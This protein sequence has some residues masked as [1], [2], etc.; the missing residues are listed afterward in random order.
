VQDQSAPSA[1]VPSLRE[2]LT[3]VRVP[4][5]EDDEDIREPVARLLTALG[6]KTQVVVTYAQ[7]EAALAGKFDVLVADLQLGSERTGRD[8]AQRSPPPSAARSQKG[9]GPRT[10]VA[11]AGSCHRAVLKEWRG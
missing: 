9:P 2:R 8:L 5:V 10:R 7:G 11:A 1:L 6:V 4:Y 3:G